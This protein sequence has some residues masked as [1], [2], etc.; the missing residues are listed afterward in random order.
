MI[1]SRQVTAEDRTR[2]A[3]AL[4][5][6]TFH[7]NTKADAFYMPGTV[8]N[9]YEDEQGNPILFVRASRSLRIDMCFFKNDAKAHNKEAMI[10]GFKQLVLLAK[11]AGFA[12]IVTSTNSEALRKFAC[13]PVDKGGFGF[14]EI[15]IEGEI[16]LRRQL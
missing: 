7:P 14:E 11:T 9:V 12:E 3:E 10:A 16:G 2:I 1:T 6:D 5:R 13:I 8:S 4:S 15:N